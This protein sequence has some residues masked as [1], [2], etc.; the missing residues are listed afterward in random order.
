MQFK[1]ERSPISTAEGTIL[2][3]FSLSPGKQGR[4]DSTWCS[5]H[6]HK[7]PAPGV[8]RLVPKAT[9]LQKVEHLHLSLEKSE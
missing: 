6:H 8:K 4:L 9:T 5:I 7:Q 3:Y 2:K 1:R